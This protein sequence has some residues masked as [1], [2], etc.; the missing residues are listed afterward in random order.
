MIDWHA[1]ALAAQRANCAY[2]EDAAQSKAAFSAL[3]DAWIGL[4]S[5]IDY[6]AV[7]SADSTGA[8]HLS[9]SGTR[10]SQGAL[11]D[12]FDD[13]D[14]VPAHV[15][16]GT[17]TA[18]VN[19]DMDKLWDWVFHTA[20]AKAVINI[21]GHS[22]GG[23]RAVLSLAYLPPSR[24]GQIVALA[25]PKFIG[26]DFYQHYADELWRLTY[27]LNDADGWASFPWDNPDWK[28]RPPI[29]IVSLGGTP[30]QYQ[31]VPGSQWQDGLDF[32][33]HDVARYVARLQAIAAIHVA[34]A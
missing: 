15:P 32:A 8:T 16:G 9:I 14:I 18:G 13:A 4:L 7:L 31:M 29:D 10:A 6:Q 5:G 22:L 23:A 19:R 26:A 20:D 12:I 2:I 30:G 11:I 25:A 24:L 17:V 21:A 33:N 3:G 28:D 34:T 27:V 1:A